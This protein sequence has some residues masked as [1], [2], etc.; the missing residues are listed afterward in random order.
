[1]LDNDLKVLNQV[2]EK[3]NS[4][5]IKFSEE[6]KKEL[7][8]TDEL[9]SNLF[10]LLN[11]QSI[12]DNILENKS[13]K[14]NTYEKEKNLNNEICKNIYFSGG[15]KIDKLF[16]KFQ[17]IED[18]GLLIQKLKNETSIEFNY[19]TKKK[20]IINY[21][22]PDNKEEL[23]NLCNIDHETFNLLLAYNH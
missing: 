2:Y 23:D 6:L 7:N 3:I 20:N 1:M 8:L 4:M 19:K 16:P 14:E 22:Y 18:K 13:L 5:K 9:Y 10:Q 17:F 15:T 21:Q 11:K 12:L